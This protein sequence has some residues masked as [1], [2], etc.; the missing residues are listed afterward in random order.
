MPR[1]RVVALTAELDLEDLGEVHDFLLDAE[2]VEGPPGFRQV[3][4][5]LWPNLL[6]KVKPPIS[7]MH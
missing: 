7:E 4:A 1:D 6:H 5:E 2:V 3:V